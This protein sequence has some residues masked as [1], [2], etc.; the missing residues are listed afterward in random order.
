MTAEQWQRVKDITADAFELEPALRAGF[1]ADACRDDSSICRE[2]LRLID[3]A[4]KAGDDFLADAPLPL[5][6]V[7]RKHAPAE[8]FFAVGELVAGRFEILKFLNRGGMGEVYAAL[9]TELKERVALKHIRRAIASSPSVIERFKQEVRQ[10]RRIAHPNVCRVYDLFSHY[11]RSGEPIWFLTMELLEGVTLA[12]RIAAGPIPLDRALPLIR[13]MAAALSA[14]HAAG[15]V[16][17]DFKPNNVMLAPTGSGAE[18]AVVTDFGLAREIAAETAD[19]AGTPAYIAP[20][21]A[22]G[23]GP[24]PAADQYS[25]GLVIGEILTG[26][27]PGRD[28]TSAAKAKAELQAWFDQQP[29]S[30]LKPRARAALETC[31]AL[32]PEDRFQSLQDL[33]SALD[34]SLHRKRTRRW[35]AGVLAA[36]TLAALVAIAARAGRTDRVTDTVCLTPETD[37]S[38]SPSLSRDGSRIAYASNRAEA[39]NLDIWIDSARGGAARRLTTSPAEDAEPS[40]APDGKSVVFHSERDGGGLYLIGGD[41]GTERLLVPGGRSPAFSP[42]GRLI[43]YWTGDPDESAPSGQLYVTSLAGPPRRIAADFAYARY[44]AWSPDGKFL[45]F[46]GCRNG[47]GPYPAC[48]EFWIARPGG[49]NIF[50]TGAMAALDAENI[51]LFPHQKAWL[52]NR[53]FFGGRRGPIDA[54]WEIDLSN[55]GPRSIGKPRQVT[56][57]EAREREPALA[58]D[59]AIAFGRLIGALHIWRISPGAPGVASQTKITDDRSQDSCPAVSRDGRWLFFTRKVNNA[60]DLF[61]KNLDN[62]TET[63]IV[64]SAAD[65]LWPLPSADGS[66]VAFEARQAQQFSIELIGQDGT[67]RRLCLGCSHPASWFAGDRA[68]FYATAKAD[69]ALLDI[70]TGTSRTVLSSPNRMVLADADWSPENEHLIFTAAGS[71]G[72]NKQ[73][74]TVAFP[75]SAAAPQGPWLLLTPEPQVAERPHWAGDGKSFF[76]LSSRDG[77]LCVWGQEFTSGEKAP[78]SSYAVM[79]YHDSPRFSPN[80]TSPVVRGLAVAGSS[81]FLNVGEGTETIWSGRLRAQS[82]LSVLREHLLPKF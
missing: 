63:M 59:G 45:L 35:A 60:R 76:Y 18:R 30:A 73:V 12:E 52:G 75:E 4:C 25:L 31:L 10:T 81:V 57:G 48:T 43:A 21:Q 20:E 16:H 9:D 82:L 61:R 53:I 66:K 28:G 17:R 67:A 13:D 79:H 29:R 11:P 34:G 42:D 2:A 38:S 70:R 26:K 33:V 24:S 50:D 23:A 74:Y 69:I 6:Q 72:K 51:V 32:R 49:G 65:K 78:H 37:W 14:A 39:G 56:L 77:H 7:L 8:P 64:E 3:E 47:S 46:E 1:V 58:A 44:P 54:L 5:H 68:I 80:R 19:S 62:G 40:I 27:R 41:G 55:A 36:G 15:I 22:A 71:G